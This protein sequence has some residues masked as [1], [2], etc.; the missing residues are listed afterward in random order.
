MATGDRIKRVRNF[1][2]MTQKELDIAVSFRYCLPDEFF[3]NGSFAKSDYPSTRL[4]NIR[5]VN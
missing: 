5:N 3:K 4:R 1:Q 2:G